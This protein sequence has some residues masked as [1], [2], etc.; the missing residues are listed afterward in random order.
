MLFFLNCL[1][2]AIYFVYDVVF[3]SSSSFSSF[4]FFIAYV[5][6]VDKWWFP[7]L[8]LVLW[9]WK[10]LFYSGWL[11]VFI[12]LRFFTIETVSALI[13]RW[14]NVKILV[15]CGTIFYAIICDGMEMKKIKI[16]ILEFFQ[17]DFFFV[18][19]FIIL[20]ISIEIF[21]LVL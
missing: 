19:V 7:Y 21:M 17:L 15:L 16:W 3:F 6:K 14:S 10:V 5:S 2:F 1:F 11:Y 20:K 9:S 8:N 18:F 13:Y 12:S 4:F